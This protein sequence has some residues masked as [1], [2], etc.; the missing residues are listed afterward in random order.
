MLLQIGER[1]AEHAPNVARK[2]AD[3]AH[4]ACIVD[5]HQLRGRR[6]RHHHHIEVSEEFVRLVGDIGLVDDDLDH[7][8]EGLRPLQRGGRAV[9]AECVARRQELRACIAGVQR[10]VLQQ[11]DRLDAGE[12]DV[13]GDFGAKAAEAAQQNASGAQSAGMC[14]LVLFVCKC[15]CV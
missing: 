4:T 12:Y 5:A 13:L 15:M 1:P 2:E 10:A 8:I 3:A 11:R 6:L 9:L 14:V 7:R